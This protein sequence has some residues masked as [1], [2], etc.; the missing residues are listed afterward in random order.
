MCC[1]RSREMRYNV[2]VCVVDEGGDV[3]PLRFVHAADLHLDSPF[4]GVGRDTPG[5]IAAALRDATFNAYERIVD[6]CIREEA[7]ALLV[8]GDVYDGRDRSL[9]AQFRFVDGL[10]RLDAAGIHAFICHGNHD[11]LDGWTARLKLPERA[12]QFGEDVTSRPF[13]P[14][15]RATVYGISYP[16]AEINENLSLKFQR[17]PEDRFAIGLLHANVGEVGDHA[18]YAPC[19]VEGLSKTG[20]DYWALGHVHT[21]TVL[22]EESPAI[23]YPGNTQGRHAREQDDRGVYLVTVDDNNRP[24]LEWT[25]VSGVHWRTRNVD[26]AG[27][28]TES[29]LLDELED[30]ASQLV[31]EETG[32]GVVVR[33]RLTGRGPLHHKLLPD[34][35]AGEF[36]N[37]LNQRME[38]RVPFFWCERISRRTAP[39]FDR[40]ERMQSEDFLGDVLRMIDGLRADPEALSELV[41]GTINTLYEGNRAGNL[42]RDRKPAGEELLSLLDAADAALLTELVDG[43]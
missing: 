41:Y 14:D 9:R 15:A 10:N 32:D 16:R 4:L 5:D 26:I 30:L 12:H 20:I 7:Q 25:A 33:I 13:G 3:E 1:V 38:H 24:H 35:V 34:G 6:L 28:E 39:P 36:R 17:C 43:R 29:D 2:C 27:F 31:D 37:Q 23:V 21:R 18:N 40:D 8:A 19:T 42:L 22:R 11:P